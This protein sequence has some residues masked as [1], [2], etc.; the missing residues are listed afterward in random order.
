MLNLEP[1]KMQKAIER[2]KAIHPKVKPISVTDRTYAVTG[3]K[4]DT[5]T[6]KFVVVNG[7]RLAECNCAAGRKGM[8]C[9]HVSAAAAVNMGLQG[10]RAAEPTTEVMADFYSK[11]VGWMI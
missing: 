10:M 4:G 8:M 1:K 2:A 11:N 5:Y 6:V 9:Y 7:L 3:S